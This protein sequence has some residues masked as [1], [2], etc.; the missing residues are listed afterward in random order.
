[1]RKKKISFK[2]AGRYIVREKQN[3]I[4]GFVCGGLREAGKV[5]KMLENEKY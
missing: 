5:K 2:D 3:Y 4:S 1:M